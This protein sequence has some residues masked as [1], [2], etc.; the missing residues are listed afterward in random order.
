MY[1]LVI[2]N[3]QIVDG[4]GAPA[5]RGSIAVEGDVIQ[6]V[7][8]VSGSAQRTIDADGR[9]VSPGFIDP[10][11][12]MDLFVKFYPTGLPVVNYG[13]TTV[14][15]GDCGASVAPV[16]QDQASL[17][18]LVTYLRRVL[19]KYVDPD[20]FEWTTFGD[21]LDY[22]EGK[23]GINLAALMPHSPTRLVVMGEESMQRAATPD[24]LRAM[25]DLVGEG[26]DAGAVGFSTSP[27]GGPL[28]HANTPSA[29]AD[30]NEMVMLA[31]SVI[32]K[33][34]LYQ[35]NAASTILD[36]ESMLSTVAAQVGG[37]YIMNEWRQYTADDAGVVADMQSR[38]QE[39]TTRGRNAYGVVIPYQHVSRCGATD[40]LPLVGLDEWQALPQDPTA[41]AHSLR[42]PDRRAR[43]ATATASH[44]PARRWASCVVRE[45]GDPADQ[46]FEGRTVLDA[47]SS[48]G[49]SPLDF[50]L[51]LLAR[52]PESARFVCWGHRA[53]GDPALLADMIQ[54]PRSVIGTDAGAHTEAFFFYG[55]PAKLLG[56]WS[57]E[58]ELLTL[59][60]AVHKLTGLPAQV[61]GIN[62]GVLQQG[63]PA[64]LVMFDPATIGDGMTGELSPDTID[65]HELERAGDGIDL[66]VVNGAVAVEAGSVT[67]EATGKVRRWEL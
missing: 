38:L 9:V 34:G 48:T 36:S 19:D 40:F 66:V 65:A 20:A 21:Y 56:H 29:F 33:G 37:T 55:A 63:R 1:D 67:S 45:V 26:W 41:F 24:E 12:H 52:N 22:L 47:A 30:V 51:D 13:V 23:V 4:T 46:R 43:F 61:L 10:H 54:S 28:I 59:E 5:Y 16:P 18:I 60:A 32:D 11:T 49:Q 27:L 2:R 31:R 53:N 3:A 50:A 17:D 6:A 64:D 57:R 58:K 42:D 44:G 8:D 7:G 14:V 62:R 15:I 35:V 39:L 25:V